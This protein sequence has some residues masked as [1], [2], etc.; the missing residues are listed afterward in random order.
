MSR[1][2]AARDY[3]ESHKKEFLEELLQF[4][5]IPSVSSDPALK[6]EVKRCAEFV[7]DRMADAGL[8]ARIFPTQG[9][10][11]VYGERIQG[12]RPTVLVYGHYDVQPPEPLSGWRHGPFEP[13]LEGDNLV[14][15]GASDDKGQI[16]SLLSGIEAALRT[17]GARGVDL[18]VLIEGEEEVGSQHLTPFV[19]SEKER[20][21]ADHVLIADTS[22]FAAGVPAITYGLKGLVYLE[23]VVRGPRKDL[24]SG[25]YGGSVMNPANALTRM[26]AA[27]QA[28]FGK[29][30]IPGFYDEVRPLE[31]WEKE[32]F[33]KLPF[34]EEEFLAEVGAPRLWGE[35]GFTTLERKWARPTFDVNGL[36]S[37]H[38]GEGSKTVLPSEARAKFSMRLVPDQKPEVIARLAEEFIRQIAPRE[39]SIEILRH[40]GASPVLVQREGPAVRAAEAALA[41]AFGRQPVFMRE[42]GSIPVVN[43]F[44]DELGA[45]SVLVGL[46]LPDDNAHSP[47]EKFALPD[48][49]RGMVVMAEFLEELG[50]AG[51]GKGKPGDKAARP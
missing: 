27:C 44:K 29:V 21:R 25:S 2:P 43:T 17:G 31:P 33:R 13:T 34:S 28:P 36:V 7:R 42:G 45:E 37:G 10:P 20:L 48:F 47:N 39:V 6:G 49:Y 32:E 14:A 1:A 16:Y 3:I 9:H 12:G 26:I 22:Q 4:L 46:G 41:A 18:K 30:A 19:R 8:T 24:H 5:R 38:T 50:A 11:L 51:G 23:L 35:E 40:H 15:R